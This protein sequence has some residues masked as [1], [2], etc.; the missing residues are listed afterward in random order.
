MKLRKYGVAI[1]AAWGGV[2][3]GF[4]VTAAFLITNVYAYYGVL[5]AFAIGMFWLS[6]RV[7]KPIVI[8]ITS[9][10]G[11]YL[12]VRGVSLYAGGFPNETALRHELDDGVINWENYEKIFYIYL[13]AIA[14]CTL[15]SFKY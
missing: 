4:V 2:M 1:L 14:L 3:L 9:F 15:I 10:M 12:L 11:S 6:L 13:G 7:E 5:G 8:G